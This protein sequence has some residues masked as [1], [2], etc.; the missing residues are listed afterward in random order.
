MAAYLIVRVQVTDPDAYEGYKKLSGP[1]VEKHG[2]R[3]LVRGGR[4]VTLEGEEETRRIVV[5]EFP[6]LER[7]EAFY[8]SPEYA[9]AIA[10]RKDAAAGQFVAVEGV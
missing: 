9:E 8:R 5:V 2:G 7:A 4:S 3:F 1:A 6:S 10:A